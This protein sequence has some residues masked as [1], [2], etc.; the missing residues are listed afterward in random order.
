V[1]RFGDPPLSREELE[2]ALGRRVKRPCP[3]CDGTIWDVPSDGTI[4]LPTQD[5]PDGP[6]KVTHEEE[7]GFVF[8][9]IVALPM[10]CRACGFI[11][12][13]RYDSLSEDTDH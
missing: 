10:V 11:A 8:E 12:Q 4:V 5:S 7:D 9:G 13:F 6:M 1:S 3:I 2:R